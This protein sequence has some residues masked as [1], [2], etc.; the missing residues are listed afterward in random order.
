[1]FKLNSHHQ[2]NS[3]NP[4][5]IF[6]AGSGLYHHHQSVTIH[7]PFSRSVVVYIQAAEIL[8]PFSHYAS[9]FLLQT[10]H[11]ITEVLSLIDSIILLKR[12]P[13]ITWPLL[14]SDTLWKPTGGFSLGALHIPDPRI[15][16]LWFKESDTPQWQYWS[17]LSNTSVN[18]C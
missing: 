6:T 1:M 9:H 13:R 3:R 11:F 2:L 14:W 8:L 15:N 12:S 5:P 4:P 7:H 18:D 16:R 17:Q 10:F